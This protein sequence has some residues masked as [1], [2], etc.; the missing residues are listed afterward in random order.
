MHTNL[1]ST[2]SFWRSEDGNYWS[3]NTKMTDNYKGEFFKNITY[4]SATTSK[5]Q[6]QIPYVD[7]NHQLNAR[8]YGDWNIEEVIKENINFLIAENKQRVQ[9]RRTKNNLECIKANVLKIKFLRDLL[10]MSQ[11]EKENLENY[12]NL[13]KKY[14]DSIDVIMDLEG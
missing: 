12:I 3:Y 11:F 1:N 8:K 9:K 10:N 7:F 4:Y 5:H 13:N 14:K 6:G 2:G